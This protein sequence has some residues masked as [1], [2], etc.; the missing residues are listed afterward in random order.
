MLRSSRSSNDIQQC[1]PISLLAIT[2]LHST[3]ASPPNVFGET[4]CIVFCGL[5]DQSPLYV[6]AQINCSKVLI[7]QPSWNE[8]V[9]GTGTLLFLVRSLAGYQ[10]RY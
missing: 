5:V 3:L 9:D 8:I 6:G 1:S 10:K 4:F 7:L 2:Q